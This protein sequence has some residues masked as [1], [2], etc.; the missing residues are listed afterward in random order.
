MVR[1]VTS[2]GRAWKLMTANKTNVLL[3]FIPIIIGLIL[4]IFAGV[5]FYSFA[6]NYGEEMVSNYISSG[7]FGSIVGFLL[8]TLI[9]ILIFFFVNWTFVM[10]V[11]V[12]AGPFNDIL[13]SRIEKQI[14]NE[15][16]W[17]LSESLKLVGS[18]FFSNLFNEIKK[19]TFIVLVGIFAFI[20]GYI[21]FFTPISIFLA[22]L[23][24]AIGFLDYS[25]SRHSVSFRSCIADVRNNLVKYSIG[26]GIFFL[27]VSVPVLNLI[28]PPLATSYF[29]LLW[30]NAHESR[31]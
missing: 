5:Q 15:Q 11:T 28:V 30:I 7:T 27:L 16:L 10:V 2:I 3:S 23:L 9:T 29:T 14:K 12:F 8:K 24:L 19:I 26:G 20:L 4:Y 21:P 13:S 25:W 18:N 31:N 1:S 22:V 6:A 17:N